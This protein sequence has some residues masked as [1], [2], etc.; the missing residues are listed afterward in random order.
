MDCNILFYYGIVCISH[1]FRRSHSAK[2]KK[3]A[4]S[5]TEKYLVDCVGMNTR[6]IIIELYNYKKLAL[7]NMGVIN[8]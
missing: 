8:P 4:I 1:I 7:K 2:K 6:L 3:P 5:Y